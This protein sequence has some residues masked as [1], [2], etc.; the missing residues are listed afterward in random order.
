MTMRK[1]LR[2]WRVAVK[3][4]I[5][6]NPKII[7]KWVNS[8]KEIPK[9]VLDRVYVDNGSTLIG[10][11]DRG[12]IYLIRGKA[13][14]WVE[15]H[16]KFHHVKRHPAKERDYRMFV[17]HELEANMSAYNKFGQPKHILSQLRGIYNDSR[18]NLYSCTKK[19]SLSAISSALTK[20]HAPKSWR[21]DFNKLKELTLSK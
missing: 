11:T 1:S 17:L 19:E 21:E 9:E 6:Y 3:N 15:T 4:E 13:A 8:Y 18:F 2:S 16:E 5:Y 10:L 7:V 12:T 14:K 20:V